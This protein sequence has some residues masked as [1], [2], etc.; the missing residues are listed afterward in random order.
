MCGWLCK[1]VNKIVYVS[2]A[3]TLMHIWVY[4]CVC[5]CVQYTYIYAESDGRALNSE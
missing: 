1:W 2:M 5:V 4:V 3:F